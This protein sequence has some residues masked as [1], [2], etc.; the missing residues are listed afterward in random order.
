[1]TILS[2]FENKDYQK[3]SINKN[4]YNWLVRIFRFVKGALKVKI[5]LKGTEKKIKD[6]EIF[7]LNHFSR[8]ET[9]IPQYLIYEKT[10]SYCCSVTHSEFFKGDETLAKLLL[11]IGGIPHDSKKLFPILAYQIL[12]GQKVIIFP[13]GGMVKDRKVIKEQDEYKIYSRTR[14]QWRA[15]HTGA[16]I[17]GI[18]VEFYKY[19]IRLA[20]EK[21][22]EKKLE[23]WNTELGINNNE[24]RELAFKKT[25]ITPLNI[26]FYPIRL[27]ENIIFKGI[28]L[29]YPGIKH[30]HYEELL[31]ES[32]IIFKN[33]E[34]TINIGDTINIGKFCDYEIFETIQ[35]NKIYKNSSYLFDIR[36]SKEPHEINLFNKFVEWSE[37]IRD[38]Y[39][40]SMYFAVTINLSHLAAGL[41]VQL[42]KNNQYKINKKEFRSLLYIVVKRIQCLQTFELQDSVNSPYAYEN[43]MY[44]NT[45]NLN[46]F[47][48]LGIN[49]DLLEESGADY[50]FKEKLLKEFEL[51]E[52]RIENPISVYANEIL[53]LPKIKEIIND[54]ISDEQADKHSIPN[55]LFDDEL[56]I[57][58]FEKENAEI[59]NKNIGSSNS[60]FLKKILEKETATADPTPFFFVSKK[61]SQSILLI[62]GL[63]ASPAE[64][65]PFAEYIYGQGFNVIGVRLI[66]HGTSPILLSDL[67]WEEWYRSVLRCYQILEIISEQI[68][69]VGFST[70]GAL[71]L[72]LAID[73]YNIKSTTAICVPIKFNNPNMM[74]ISLLHGVNR[75][76]QWV[77]T[78][79]VFKDFYINDTEHPHINYRHVPVSALYQ[80]R[81]LIE[82]VENNLDKINC[83][84]TLIQGTN[85]PVVDPVSSKILYEK[86][87]TPDVSLI[88]IESE[89]HGILYQNIRNVWQRI[90]D[91]IKIANY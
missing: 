39:S 86:L 17:L 49:A 84:V 75:L 41:I 24:L 50:I 85:D 25:I 15:Q 57:F 18:A 27:T 10:K 56:R 80:L 23:F 21:N 28:K 14:E 61:N 70:G 22:D 81:L 40:H 79:D 60:S 72:K 53:V 6:G 29:F 1:M 65:K 64:I 48:M 89:K 63:L 76:S 87:L 51:D 33:T 83:P 69:V 44:E 3:Y 36:Q 71:G 38:Q 68:H 91:N 13:E 90:H 73:Q 78:K 54:S 46:R 20:I 8:F 30:R 45:K 34:M 55:C 5:E 37:K 35:L 7:V 42:Y 12:K 82:V 58:K 4:T 11:D 67:H 26:T 9:F 66:G 88:K 43:L 59:Q 31:I 52:V 62:H 19:L 16:A 74:L 32:N 77:T 2:D 47:I